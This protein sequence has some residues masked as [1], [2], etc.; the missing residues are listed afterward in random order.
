MLG[1]IKRLLEESRGRAAQSINAVLTAAYW[2]IGRRIVEFEQGGRVR[3]AYGEALIKRLS[4]DLTRRHG[5][6]FSERNLEQMRLFYLS[7]PISQT[8]SAKSDKPMFPLSWSHYV[9]ILSIDDLQ[10]R[11]FYEAEA[12]R[13]GWSVRQMDRQISSQFY[14]R[15]ALSK[16]KT[17]MLLKASQRTPEDR[18]LP[19]N[20]IKD[21]YILEF[22]NL[23]D[24]YSESDLEDALIRHLEWFL[25][26]MG[27]EFAFIARQKRLRVG[28]AWYRIDLVLYHRRLRCLVLIDLKL[29][30]FTH[31]D[32]GQMHLYL[33]YA[34]EHWMLP[35]E[36]PPDAA[37]LAAE[38]SKARLALRA[39]FS[40]GVAH[41]RL[42]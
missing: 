33:N 27:G 28:D 23:K 40:I 41:D 9:L 10:A 21:P 24:E 30:R 4:S 19:E 31:A 15:T 32:A 14:E 3:A 8:P 39:P 35:G 17:A 22:L 5:R 6:G 42:R 2:E 7:R 36:N 29:D 16:N 26:E 11:E 25:L 37:K 20:E 34:R 18:P 13:G 38:I 12:L 1:G